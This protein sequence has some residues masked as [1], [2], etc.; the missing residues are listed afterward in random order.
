MTG[1]GG[2]GVQLLAKLLAHAAMREGR[3]VLT[4][5][6]FM[7]MIRG[8]SSES[9][10]VVADAEITLPPIVPRAWGVVALHGSGLAPLAAKAEPGGILVV[11]TSLVPAPPEWPGVRR[12]DVAATALA[13][14]LGQPLGA[15][16]V[17][18]GAFAAASGLVAPVSLVGALDEVLPAHR[19]A[20]V[21][22]N[23]AC[24][25]AGAAAIEGAHAAR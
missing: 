17:A 8:G 2:Q 7:G 11:N 13:A 5:G 15:G 22:G 21:D 25:L 14:G 6:I 12:V 9:T 10:V 4:F 20:L 3:D 19:R 24:L 23:R 1:V 16:M 18:L